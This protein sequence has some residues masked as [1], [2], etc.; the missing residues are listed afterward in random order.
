MPTNI[1]SP[2]EHQRLSTIPL[3]ISDDELMRF[4]TTHQADLT[5]IDP[6]GK[7][8]HRL[9]QAA[10]LCLLR[11]LGWS[12]KS[13]EHLPQTALAALCEQLHLKVPDRL[14]P[15]TPRTSRLHAQ[16]ARKHLGWRRYTDALEHSVGE[17][18]RS[19]A[20]EH[21]RGSVLLD[22]LLRHLYREKIVRPGLTVL[23]RLVG[24]VRGSVTDS[25]A[26]AINAQLTAEQKAQ[27]DDLV[28]VPA[29]ETCSPL[30]RFKETPPKSTRPHLLAVLERIEA[31]RAIGVDRLDLSSVHPNRAKLM[32][33]RVKRRENWSTARLRP[34]HRYPLLVCFLDQMLPVLADYA[35][36]MH[37]TAVQG[38]FSTAEK[39]RDDEVMRRGRSL[40]EKVL[41]LAQLIRLILDEEGVSDA[42][43]RAAI[44]T[45]VPR[46]RL[47]HTVL[48]CDEIAQPADFAPF[49]FAENHYSH[50]RSF[51]PHFLRTLELQAEEA[52]MPLLKAVAFIQA[53]DGGEREFVEPPLAFVPWRWK[54]YVSGGGDG[55]GVSRRM[56][57]LCL[58][59]CVTKALDRGELGVS[60]S[61]TYSSFRNDWI[62]DDDWPAARTA[63][64]NRYSH[65][66]DVNEFIEH[67]RETLD[68]QMAAAN[69]VWPDLQDEAKVWIGEDGTLH[70][71]RLEAQEL[72][73]QY[74]PKS[75][76]KSG[77]ALSLYTHVSDHAMPYYG[78]VI[79][80]LSQEGAYVLD[81]LLYHETD[82]SPERHFVDTGGYQDTLWGDCHLLGFSLEPRIR[83]IGEMRLFRMRRSVQQC[84]HIRALFSASINARVIREHWE[85]LLRLMAS[86]YAGI[87]PASRVLA[88]LNAYHVESGLYKALREVGRIAKT[89]FLLRFC[90][91]P[92]ARRDVQVGLNRQESVHALIR[93][94][95][96]GQLGEFRARDLSAQLN[97]ASCLQLVAAMVIT[98]D[99][100]YLAAAVDKLRS[101]DVAIT[102]EHLAHIL[103]VASGHINLLG[104]YEFDATAPSVHKSI[105][106]LPLRSMNEIIEQLGLGI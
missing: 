78:Q 56:Y 53:V 14:R 40:N 11:W 86:I 95:F 75:P 71:A 88:K 46:D 29:G 32:A 60:G 64:L 90:T 42:E 39:K 2:E 58:H 7:P 6:L 100:A 102:D 47:A 33:Q 51:G 52:D 37:G 99:A 82:L 98:W 4:F 105:S 61:Q 89:S 17:W 8:A 57:E 5:Q 93:S 36:Q 68:A 73:P 62:S 25:I 43:L 30:Q 12:P 81:G 24:T 28:V 76:S 21:D 92:T 54:P 79:H 94:L 23:E 45:S 34:E 20:E 18:L 72:P 19:L 96:V 31:I 38:I 91:D 55:K 87:V 9:D 63:F 22:A 77:R 50:L 84:E 10:H 49:S 66:A 85:D 15:P 59:D 44:Y 106:D 104:R 103:P 67:A 80:H 1:L 69:S 13:V 27:L 3:E 48:E 101:E 65:L 41:L 70:L 83:D 97:R 16:R 26:E 74:H 35:V